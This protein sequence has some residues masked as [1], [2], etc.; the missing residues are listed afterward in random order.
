MIGTAEGQVG[1]HIRLTSLTKS[2]GPG[3]APAVDNIEMEIVPGEFLTL[4]G[5]SGSG[6][7]TTLNMIA[8]FLE[9]TSGR[10]E[11]NGRDISTTPPH[12]R[13]FGMVFQNYALFPHLSVR[14]NVAFPLKQR[15]VPKSEQAD[16]VR[17]ALELVDLAGMEERLPSALSGGQQQRVALARAVVYSPHL[18][19]L[20]EP[21]GALDRRLRQSLQ[22]E[23]KR[24]H[25]ELGLTFLFVTHDQD[26]AMSLSDRIAVFHDGRIER[27]GA[28]VEL[29]DNPGTLFV[30]E[31][32]GESNRFFGR[33]EG[34]DYIWAESPMRVGMA[35]PVDSDDVL[36]VRPERVQVALDRDAVPEGANV[37]SA[38]VVDSAYLGTVRRV[39]LQYYDGQSGV[40]LLPAT[41]AELPRPGDAVHVHWWP[42]D[43]VFVRRS[44]SNES[45]TS[46]QTAS[47]S[48]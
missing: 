25:R 48:R 32:L 38:K 11:L 36:V 45:A 28:P 9:P 37:A 17:T 2:Y 31:F 30:A 15:K 12:R 29:Y 13:N 19:L 33:R 44:A 14:Q 18:L 42:K 4:L 35:R 8:G 23:I 46:G 20:D 34:A 1:A 24:I 40:A 41:S 7:T 3:L 26:E 39:D 47:Q 5:A 10:I 6:K 16:R 21:L 27:L 43:Q 22:G